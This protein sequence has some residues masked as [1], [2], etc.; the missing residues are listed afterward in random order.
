MNARQ[1]LTQA[2]L[3]AQLGQVT[4]STH[5]RRDRAYR[6]IRFE[7]LTAALMTATTAVPEDNGKWLL[8]GGVDALG[9]PLQVVVVFRR[10]VL[11]VTAF[12][13]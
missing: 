2:A 8:S 6:H 12:E 10:D 1:A 3:A 4:L 13:G 7:D 11:V 5:F 9:D